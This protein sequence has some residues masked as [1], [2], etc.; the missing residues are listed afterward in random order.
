MRRVNS[1]SYSNIY[2]SLCTTFAS[3]S[4]KSRLNQCNSKW[5]RRTIRLTFSNLETRDLQIQE[6]F[7]VLRII[8]RN[9]GVDMLFISKFRRFG[10]LFF[11]NT[12][13]IERRRNKRL[14]QSVFFPRGTQ[15]P[16]NAHVSLFPS[17]LWNSKHGEPGL[18][19][20]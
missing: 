14:C 8:D 13:I 10:S 15:V 2:A 19:F 17:L 7:F 6:P 20:L 3:R 4:Y 18:P 9:V 16:P 1:N 11:P 5:T 12:F